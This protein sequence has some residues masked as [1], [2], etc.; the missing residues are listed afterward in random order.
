M[1]GWQPIETAPRDGRTILAWG[2]YS[3]EPATVKWEKQGNAAPCWVPNWD[4]QWVI[5]HQGD[6]GTEY[7]SAAPLTHWQPLPAPPEAAS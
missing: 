2:P 3:S 7:K 5:E 1:S 6:F 4:E